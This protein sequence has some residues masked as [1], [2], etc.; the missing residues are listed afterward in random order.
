M[1]QNGQPDNPRSARYILKDFVNGKLL[2]CDAPPDQL[3]SEFHVFPPRRKIISSERIQPARALRASRGV[4]TTG[5]DVDKMFFQSRTTG[6]HIRGG[7][8]RNYR[9]VNG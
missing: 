9:P 4:R 8:A 6:S 2:Y 7:D 3:Q 5:G 1:T